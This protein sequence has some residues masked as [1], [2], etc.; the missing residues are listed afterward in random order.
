MPNIPV[1]PHFVEIKFKV[2][3]D[4]Y[5]EHVTSAKFIKTDQPEASFR[6]VGGKTHKRV[7]KAA[8]ALQI[9]LV[10][11][12]SATGL[13]RMF[14]EDEGQQAQVTYEDETGSFAATVNI[15]APDPGGEGG[16]FAQDSLTLPV[17]GVV[18]FTPTT[19]P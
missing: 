12:W 13:A 10:Q 2:G 16:T 5:T 3:T 6:D 8:R 14:W 1:N 18:S 7:G 9:N 15:I 11:D 17:D 19:T 4:E